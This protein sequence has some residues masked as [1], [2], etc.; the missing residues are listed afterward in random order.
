MIGLRH[1]IAPVVL[2]VCAGLI[3]GLPCLLFGF[4][5]YGDDSISHAI[6]YTH[7]AE[8]L[9]SGDAYPRWLGQLNGGLGSAFFFFYSPLPYY[10]T[11]ILKPF[12]RSD[13]HGWLQLGVGACAAVVA[14]GLVFYLWIKSCASRSGAMIG[15]IVYMA[16]PYH[17]N[18]DL[19]T[20]GA[21][22]ELWSFVCM[23][24]VLKGIDSF[25][26]NRLRG[27]VWL[28]LAYSAL[29]LSSLPIALIFSPVAL[30][31]ALLGLPREQRLKNAALFVCAF[32]LGTAVS[33]VY[34][35]PAI[36]L[37][38]FTFL[39]EGSVG[40]YFYG[41]WFL[42]TDLNWSSVRSDIFWFTL[43][44]VALALVAFLVARRDRQV[45]FWLVVA[46]LTFALMTPVSKPVWAVI[47]V[48][49]EIQ[50]PWRF[51]T[52]LTLATATLVGFA[53]TAT[54]S[55]LRGGI[56]L[57]VILVIL[58][59]VWLYDLGRRAWVSYPVN[60]VDQAV[61][62]ER[63]RW[64]E[65]QRDQ[66]EFRPRWVVSIREQELEALLSRI[67]KEPHAP[68][69]TSVQGVGTVSIERWDRNGIVLAVH[70]PEPTAVNVSQ[71]YFPGWAATSE[72]GNALE[73][74]PSVPGGL[75]SIS[76]PAGN[77]KVILKRVHT[78]PELIGIAISGG[79]ALLCLILLARAFRRPSKEAITSAPAN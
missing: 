59:G 31:Y 60:Y 44:V 52:I 11:S 75:V 38:R 56:L 43:A 45:W 41:N 28:S 30:S 27:L 10:L 63:S 48:L 79:A 3:L 46:V 76:V 64:L 70:T 40:H 18:I 5:F 58:V 8:R 36:A 4:P 50:F 21:Y 54:T 37:K 24:L 66:N 19:Y 13:A 26:K 61:V 15:S 22:S 47:S 78:R 51:N 7:F 17:V 35:L 69:V 33:A 20:R 49:Q 72:D 65:Q 39:S 32:V 57:R 77:R 55:R 29:I 42:F 62:T 71:F 25:S 67:G 1:K 34:V 73:I 14:S 6:T 12:F 2:I 9:W 23:P 53:F 68:G 16:L 74:R